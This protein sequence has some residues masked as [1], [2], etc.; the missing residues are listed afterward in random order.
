M[1]YNYSVIIPHH[2]IPTMLERAIKSVPFRDDVEIIVVDD[3]SDE[4]YK[5]KIKEI[6]TLRNT[7]IK[8]VLL[9]ENGGG[10]KARNKGLDIAQGKFVVFLDADDFFN[11]CINQ[12][13]DD[14]KDVDT[15]IIFFR[16]GSIDDQTYL[17]LHRADRIN[18]CVNDFLNSAPDC[19]YEIR[20]EQGC[21]VSKFIKRSLLEEHNIR[22]EEIR[23]HNDVRFS[24]TS[25]FYAKKIVADPRAIY[26][27]TTRSDSVSM[28]VSAEAR[29]LRVNVTADFIKFKKEHGLKIG[30]E[31]LLFDTMAEIF[32]K[33]KFV[34]NKGLEKI[35]TIG[36]SKEFITKRLRRAIRNHQIRMFFSPRV[37]TILKKF[38][39]VRR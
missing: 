33:D 10:G 3:A 38:L 26:C 37:R 9:A 34:Y 30:N 12:A 28:D 13:M 23:K 6:C 11:Y 2:N 1:K 32:F 21:P 16:A 19:D 7:Q 22:F 36:L 18:S 14:Y 27:I 5:P 8:L 15:D 24:Y 39:K 31:E 35:R 29:L 25:G 4:K 17:P 20:Y